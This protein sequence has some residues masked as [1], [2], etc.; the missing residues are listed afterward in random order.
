MSFWKQRPVFIT[1][2]TGLLG[3]WLTRRLVNAGA[4][5]VCLVRD[6]V[7][8]SEL[9]RSGMLSK[10]RIVRGDVCDQATLERILG[11]YEIESVFHAAAQTIVGVSNRNPVSTFESNIGGT[12]SLLEACR[13]SP[14]VRQIVVASSDKAYGS[15]DQLPYLESMPLEGRHPYDV[16]KSCADLICRSYASTWGVPVAVT[17]CG[18][19]FGG[20]DLNWSRII[21]GTIRSV[22]NHERPVIRSDG[23]FIRDYFFVEDAAEAY[24]LLAERMSQDRSLTGEAFNFSLELH[25]SVLDV[26]EMILRLMNSDLRPDIRNEADKEIRHQY[27]SAAKAHERL[28]W[29]PV[30]TMEEGL[31]KTIE[32]YAEFFGQPGAG[33]GSDVP[34]IVELRGMGASHD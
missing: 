15:Q 18:N 1:G 9:V 24:M 26:V 14:A 30:Y 34:A 21:P 13:R 29:K 10:V 4:D 11:E 28:S 20:G 25:L 6:W 27:L 16:S 32:W 3:S 33:S 12:W 19:L 8:Q 5:V 2:A 17:R 31:R 7:P 22:F 23:K